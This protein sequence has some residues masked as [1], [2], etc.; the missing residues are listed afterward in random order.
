[1]AAHLIA[2]GEEPGASA[3]GHCRLRCGLPD[4]AH[5]ELTIAPAVLAELADGSV[6]GAEPGSPTALRLARLIEGGARPLLVHGAALEFLAACLDPAA[7]P[8]AIPRRERI[9]LIAA[10]DRLLRDLSAAP[11]IADLARETGL[12][13]RKLK[14]GFKRMFGLGVHALF[15]R[16]RMDRARVLLA[17]QGVTATA[18]TL[19]YS[20]ASHFSAA[21][22]KQFGVAPREMRCQAVACHNAA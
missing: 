12:N 22:R 18:M 11:T 10:R 5:I 19:G 13:Q 20:N 4:G 7:P 16:A 21:F 17:R 14:Q 8:D 15:Q 3:P 1:M 6:G 9:L 2:A